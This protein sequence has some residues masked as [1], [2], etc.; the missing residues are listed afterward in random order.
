MSRLQTLESVPKANS[1]LRKAYATIQPVSR[2]CTV[3]RMEVP[4]KASWEGWILL[5]SDAHHDNAKC[6]RTLE[7]QHLDEAIAR[8]AL[9]MD[10]GDL[11]CAMQGKFDPRSSR[12]AVTPEQQGRNDYL[13]VL[14]DEATQFYSPY[15]ANW[16]TMSHGNH[17]TGILNRCGV[18]LTAFLAE[19]LEVPAMSYGGFIRLQF[20]RQGAGWKES[21]IIAY[22][23]G[24]GV[25]GPVTRGVIGTARRA[26]IW[27]DAD[28]V[29]SG[30]THESWTVVVPQQKL[31]AQNRIT[32]RDTLHI[33]TPGYK[34][35]HSC[36]EGWAVE[37]GLNP[38]PLGAAW[39]RLIVRNDK[40]RIEAQQALA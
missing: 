25:G 23:H 16:A 30:H 32:R 35:E 37:K 36:M 21:K 29:W 15:K 40:I 33:S 27:P 38:K 14:I 22:H 17:E 18:D 5:R 20:S 34:D 9:I 11:F 8:N 19:R 2:Q 7:K 24:H 13:N 6:N 10:C 39:L 12:S 31:N 28:V 3:I 4:N 1:P 26:A